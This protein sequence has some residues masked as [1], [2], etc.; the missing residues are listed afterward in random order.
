VTANRPRDL[1]R[2]ADVRHRVRLSAWSTLAICTFRGVSSASARGLAP[3]YLGLVQPPRLPVCASGS[4]TVQLNR[5][6]APTSLLNKFAL[7][8]KTCLISFG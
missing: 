7:V 5:A 6:V 1:K 4:A 3:T 2:A 8:V